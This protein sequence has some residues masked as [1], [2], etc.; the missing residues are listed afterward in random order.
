M[1][2]YL[3]ILAQFIFYFPTLICSSDSLHT[4]INLFG[5]NFYQEKLASSN[6]NELFSP[7]C[8]FNCLSMAYLGSEAETKEG[9]RKTLNLDLSKD[10][11]AYFLNEFA[12]NSRSLKD[13]KNFCFNVANSLWIDQNTNILPSYTSILQDDLKAHLEHIVFSNPLKSST[14]INNWVKEQTRNTIPALLSPQDISKD[15]QLM[16]VSTLYF[17]GSWAKPF[18]KYMT[19]EETFYP[20]SNSSKLVPTMHQV[21]SLPYYENETMQLVL[22]PFSG[23]NMSGG[24]LACF[25]VLPKNTLEEI[26][27]SLNSLS[28]QSWIQEAKRTK[29]DLAIPKFTIQPKYDLIS[30]LSK[31]GMKSAFSPQ[32]NFSKITGKCNLTINKVIHEAFFALDEKGVTASAATAVGVAATCIY[33]A[34]VTPIPFIANHPF[35]FG[36][37]D[38]NSNVVLFLGK[39]VNP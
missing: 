27:S 4:S 31:L 35:L 6:K 28:L 1:K 34:P 12:Q 19:Q 23:R 24:Q 3:C 5:A 16:L 30:T 9:M 22:L 10:E 29:V 17:K 2:K 39:M 32:A 14:T 21:E 20:T 8:L 37:V 26:E 25:F 13:E 38:L 15:T 11:L 7:Y 36:I 18:L 33:R